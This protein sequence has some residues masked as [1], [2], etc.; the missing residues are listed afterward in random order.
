MDLGT[1]PVFD[2]HCHQPVRGWHRLDPAAFRAFFTEGREPGSADLAAETP[3]YRWAV[4]ALADLLGCAPT[5]SAVLARRAELGPTELV[6]RFVTDGRILGLAVDT[7]YRAAE[8]LTLDELR[9]LVGPGCAI[10]PVF[11]LEPFFEELVLALPVGGDPRADLGRLVGRVQDEVRHLPARGYVGLKTIIAYR[12]GLELRPPD[13]ERAAAALAEVKAAARASGR[14][15]GPLRLASKPLLDQLVW[16]ALEAADG[17]RLPVQVHTG[18][19]DADLRLPEADPALL[20]DA[21]ELGG[22]RRARIVLLHCWPYLRS[23]AWLASVYP[24]V[25]LDLSYTIPFLGPALPTALE[26]ALAFTPSTR[27][28]Y[29]SDAPGLPDLLWLGAIQA[30]RA[31]VTVLERWVARGDLDEPAARE[32]AERVLWRNAADLYGLPTSPERG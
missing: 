25:Y 30:R 28:L 6:R 5:E 26:E 22:F 32:L 7:G 9:G 24:N 4:R 12:S 2:S 13:P 16:A 17:A 1:L 19:G 10:R 27:L 18:L 29:G 11:R 31:L 14:L 21:L 3:F 15:R 23:A 20:R 8:S